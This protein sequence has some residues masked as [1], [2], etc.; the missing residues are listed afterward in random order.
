LNEDHYQNIIGLLKDAQKGLT[1]EE[2]SKALNLSRITTT[3]Y[4]NSLFVSGQVNMRK[5]GPAKVYTLS[6]RLPFDQILGQSSDLILV[7]DETYTVRKV[8]DSFLQAFGISKDHIENLDINTT[9]IGPVL[10]DRIRGPVKQ[11]MAGKESVANEWV[12]V[13]K[14]WKVFRIR[15]IPLVFGWGEKGVVIMLE[16]RT[17]E[18]MAHEESALLADLVNAS[19]AAIT[20]S[21]FMGNFLYS[22]KKNLDL[23]GYSLSEFLDLNLRDLDI[24][25]SEKPIAERLEDLKKFGEASF[26]VLHF[27]KDGRQIP[28]EVHAK[29]ARWG[30]RDVVISI[31][32][33]ISERKRAEKELRESE[34]KFATIFQSNPVSLA[35]VSETDGVFVDVNDT[36]S[37]NAGYTRAEIIGKTSEE[38]GIFPDTA[39]Y[40]HM[41]SLLRDQRQINSMELA[42]RI[43][44]GEIRTCR[45]SSK[46]I[47]MGDRPHILSMVE[48]I[49]DRKHAEEALYQQ[50]LVLETINQLALEFASLPRGKS[51]PEQAVKKLMELSGA[52]VTL[53]LVYNP[54]DRTLQVTNFEIAPGMLEKVIRVLGKRPGDVKTPVSDNMYQEI[55]SAITGR[56]ETLTEASFGQIPPL[57]SMSIQKLLGIDRFIG[58]A[59]VIEGMLY[60]TSLLAMKPGQPDP[61]PELLES[62]AHIVAI[63]L[64]RDRDEPGT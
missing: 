7:L 63:S 33:D 60:G 49:T 58:I 20:V 10:I 31:A 29:T 8:N 53:F 37:I 12:P 6:T 30:D 9:F 64:R 35:L 4:L 38:I 23:H 46:V 43:K 21:D 54:Y 24:P 48:D 1:I 2:I 17:G 34:Q 39:A 14:D 27:R 36:F 44:T 25:K 52:A 61:S 51:V 59:Y 18:I 50:N 47:M 22:N 42:C 15:I 26:E 41:V 11:G 45:F 3:K 32:T 55:I 28:L 5:A 16:D 57:V 40:T 19:S 62:F 13:Q 56:R